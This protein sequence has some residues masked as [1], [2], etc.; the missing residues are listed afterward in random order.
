MIDCRALERGLSFDKLTFLD[1]IKR[2]L[3]LSI[4]KHRIRMFILSFS[5][6]KLVLIDRFRS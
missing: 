1:F 2:D 6:I 3:V 5:L 4:K